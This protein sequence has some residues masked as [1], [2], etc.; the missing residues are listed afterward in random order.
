MKGPIP[1]KKDVLDLVNAAAPDVRP[2]LSAIRALG[3]LIAYRGSR[4]A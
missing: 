1:L 2:G 4:L 3:F